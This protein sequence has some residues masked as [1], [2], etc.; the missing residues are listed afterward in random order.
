MDPGGEQKFH[1][2]RVRSEE[3]RSISRWRVLRFAGCGLLAGDA[4]LFL[5]LLPVF[6][7]NLDRLIIYGMFS[8]AGWAL[9][10]LLIALITPPSLFVPPTLAGAAA[11]RSETGAHRAVLD[12]RLILRW[13]FLKM[14][15]AA[16]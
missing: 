12:F 7:R 4:A 8:L 15:P 3:R 1:A 5:T 10:G 13:R 11:H 9:V 14:A 6:W 2:Q 16:Q